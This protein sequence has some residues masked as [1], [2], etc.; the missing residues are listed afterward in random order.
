MIDFV[1]KKAMTEYI[2]VNFPLTELEFERGNGEGMWVLVTKGTKRDYDHDAFGG[3]YI[4]IL[5]NDSAYYPGLVHG[6]VVVFEMRGP[7]RPVAL[8]R[9]FLSR[10]EKISQ[11]EKEE[12]IRKIAAN[13]D[14]YEE[15]V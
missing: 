2:Q 11:E 10:Y 15:E 12:L 6:S 13:C 5:D 7:N 14:G 8:F 3:R 4:G 9:S 1:N